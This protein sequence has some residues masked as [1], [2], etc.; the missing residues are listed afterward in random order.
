MP[1]PFDPECPADFTPCFED[2]FLKLVP[3]VFLLVAGLPRLI[4]LSKQQ[5]LRYPSTSWRQTLKL[6]GIVA[7]IAISIATLAQ[8]SFDYGRHG[9]FHHIGLELLSSLLEILS[10]VLALALTVV[11]NKK[12]YLSSNVLLVY[13][14][15]LIITSSIK[16][17]TLTLGCPVED[18]DGL[19][20]PSKRQQ[21][22]IIGLLSG[23]IIDAILVFSLECV[24]RDAGIQL[25]EDN[26]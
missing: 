10:L 15:F 24:H 22:L 6:I 21:Q 4:K 3:V 20:K 19:G 12:S 7:L 5:S 8:D 1:G 11:E 18:L 25:G 26:Y 9:I 13:W 2:T 23:K 14:L 16:L 17:R